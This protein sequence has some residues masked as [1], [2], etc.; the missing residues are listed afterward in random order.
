MIRQNAYNLLRVLEKSN[1]LKFSKLIEWIS[2]I[3]KIDTCW[4]SMQTSSYICVHASIFVTMRQRR[5]LLH[6]FFVYISPCVDLYDLMFH[7]DININMRPCYNCHTVVMCTY[8]TCVFYSICRMLLGGT[9]SLW[10]WHHVKHTYLTFRVRMHYFV[11][12]EFGLFNHLWY[13]H[14]DIQ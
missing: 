9:H 5:Q 4:C 7:A 1:L 2:V 11:D 13:N 3:L 12:V 8:F 10:C 14:H 6:D